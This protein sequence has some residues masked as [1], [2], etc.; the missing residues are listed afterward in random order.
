MDILATSYTLPSEDQLVLKSSQL[1]DS[2]TPINTLKTSGSSYPPNFVHV[3]V[4]NSEYSKDV[5]ITGSTTGSVSPQI[6]SSAYINDSETLCVPTGDID[7]HIKPRPAKSTTLFSTAPQTETNKEAY[8]SIVPTSSP[9]TIIALQPVAPPSPSQPEVESTNLSSNLVASS[10]ISI[11]SASGTLV[12][13]E[14]Q[15]RLST[16]ITHPPH[17]LSRT[18]TAY[19]IAAYPAPFDPKQ[20][21]ATLQ[22]LT[23]LTEQFEALND[24]LLDALTS[25]DESRLGL[26]FASAAG[27][28]LTTEPATKDESYTDLEIERRVVAQSLVELIFSSW[29]RLAGAG[30]T[31][32]YPT[33]NLPI[34][35][36]PPAQKM[37]R[38]NKPQIKA[39]THLKN[40]IVAF[41]SAQSNFHDRA[42]LVLEIFQV[43]LK[44]AIL[45]NLNGVVRTWWHN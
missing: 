11:L 41:W 33:L 21:R 10:A 44:H 30:S 20:L 16:S 35:T 8:T 38:L 45:D 31:T 14:V 37:V 15:G 13:H 18:T 36:P 4:D 12:S 28:H 2:I 3:D 6:Q 17:P 23:D 32:V 25:Y 29:S 22:K 24:Q 5:G 7:T 42:Q 43:Q 19:T 1:D 9:T 39:A 26:D 27:S 34:Q 40:I